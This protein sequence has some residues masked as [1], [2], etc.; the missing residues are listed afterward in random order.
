MHSTRKNAQIHRLT[1]QLN[2]KTKAY[3][4]SLVARL[5]ESEERL[6][7][8]EKEKWKLEADVERHKN[9]VRLRSRTYL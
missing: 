8:V 4:D 6:A 2:H 3:T 5:G 1:A 9:T 7:V